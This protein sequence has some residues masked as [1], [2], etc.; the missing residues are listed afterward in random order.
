[1]NAPIPPQIR[2]SNAKKELGFGMPPSFFS[3]DTA[4]ALAKIMAAPAS[5]GIVVESAQWNVV[6]PILDAFMGTFGKVIAPFNTPN[7]Q[8]PNGVAAASNTLQDPD[9]ELRHGRSRRPD[10]LA[11]RAREP[12]DPGKR[13]Q[14]DGHRD[15]ARK[16]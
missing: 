13:L 11:R 9:A 14:P 6:I 1:M 7:G 10:A 3:Q 4:M 15:S 5:R 16:P 12:L 2:M 8:P